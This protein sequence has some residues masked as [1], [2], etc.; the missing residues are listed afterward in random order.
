LGDDKDDKSFGYYQSG[1]VWNKGTTPYS[2]E[3]YDTSD[4]VGCCIH[5]TKNIL[6]FTKNGKKLDP[7]VSIQETGLGQVDLYAAF[8]IYGYEIKSGAAA[9]VNFGQYPFK[10]NIRDYVDVLIT[11]SD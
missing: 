8:S 11:I 5:R 1:E 7:E 9:T 4:I 2:L 3:A 10:F 6:F